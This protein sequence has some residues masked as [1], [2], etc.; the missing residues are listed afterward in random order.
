MRR[1]FT[2]GLMAAAFC[3]AMV[4]AQ[5]ATASAA[6]GHPGSAPAYARHTPAPDATNGGTDWFA[7]LG[8]H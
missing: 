3:V 6:T 5:G 2:A 4:A 7:I 1:I 8:S